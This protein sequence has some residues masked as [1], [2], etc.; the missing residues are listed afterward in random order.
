[1][2]TKKTGL[3][4]FSRSILGRWQSLCS[5][6]RSS[7]LGLHPGSE[8]SSLSW[9][10]EA[11]WPTRPSLRAERRKTKLTVLQCQVSVQIAV[12]L[13]WD[14]KGGEKKLHKWKT[15][16]TVVLDDNLGGNSV[17]ATMVTSLSV[18]HSWYELSL[19]MPSLSLTYSVHREGI[20]SNLGQLKPN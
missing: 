2:Y 13:A 15:E 1:M 6:I 9:H 4:E 11:A 12:H 20:S 3:R 17:Y 18:T 16:I 10:A 7:N 8:V 5:S 14:N 19:Q